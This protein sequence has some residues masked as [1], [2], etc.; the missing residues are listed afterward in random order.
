MNLPFKDNQA[1]F[2][3]AC[4][5]LICTVGAGAMLPALVSDGRSLGVREP[6]RSNE[7]GTQT[8]VLKVASRD[9]GFLVVAQT[10][11][12]GPQLLPGDFV[13]WQAGVHSR[14]LGE[15]SPDERFG[16]IGLILGKLRPEWAG[17]GWV[18]G[19]RFLI[20]PRTAK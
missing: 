2:E 6:V 11:G 13:A 8:A 9:G 1:A 3:Y 17:G 7:D 16:W 5:F 10:I 20:G 4:A 19:E 12:S 14:E 15:A 18:G